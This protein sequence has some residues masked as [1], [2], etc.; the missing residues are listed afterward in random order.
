MKILLYLAGATALASAPVFAA[1]QTVSLPQIKN[2]GGANV[3]SQGSVLIGSDGTE[4]GT[5]ANPVVVTGGGGG[6]STPTGSAGA[7]NASV[8]TVQGI[9]GATPL[10]IAGAVS[11]ADQYGSGTIAAGT[12]N[13]AYTLPIANGAGVA[14]FTVNGLTAATAT[15]AIETSNDKGTTWTAA[16]GLQGSTGALFSTVS[17]DGQFRVNTGGRT[18][19]R[20]RVASTGSGTINVTSNLSV[21]STEIAMSSPLPPGMNAIGAVSAVTY[22]ATS[23]PLTGTSTAAQVAGPFV[24]VLGRPITVALSAATW[25]GGTAQ[26]LRSIDGGGTKLPLTPA[27]VTLGT[28]TQQGVD[29]PWI[30]TEA[31]ATF[32]LSLPASGIGFRVSQ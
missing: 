5:A 21:A 23:A 8:V 19:V 16:N 22:A 29:Q 7:P 15:L 31:G 20:L 30:E 6:G 10:A 24:P 9:T 4:K 11:Q 18:M 27:G 14:G 13:A 12:T 26:I 17:A 3:P 28:Y 25:P 1:A 32:Y 2:A